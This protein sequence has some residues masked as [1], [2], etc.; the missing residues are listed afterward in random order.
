MKGRVED[1]SGK[2]REEICLNQLQLMSVT[3][4]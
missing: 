3:G 4:N 2:V 1:F